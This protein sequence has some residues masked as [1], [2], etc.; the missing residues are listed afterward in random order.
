L[1][2]E[3][4]YGEGGGGAGRYKGAKEKKLRKGRDE[5]K[6]VEKER[7]EGGEA[8]GVRDK[9]KKEKKRRSEGGES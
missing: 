8:Q 1:R 7:S 4:S 2:E 3:E 5:M 6:I 9:M